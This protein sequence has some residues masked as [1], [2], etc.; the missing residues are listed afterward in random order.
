MLA[1]VEL[2]ILAGRLVYKKVLYVEC[3]VEFD[4]VPRRDFD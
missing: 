2:F 3:I 4:S 1:L